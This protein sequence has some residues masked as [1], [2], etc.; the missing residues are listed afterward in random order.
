MH[1]VLLLSLCGVSVCGVDAAS[2]TSAL[3]TISV[4]SKRFLSPTATPAPTPEAI[5]YNS[6]GFNGTY[7]TLS[8][9]FSELMKNV[10]SDASPLS[11]SKVSGD[12]CGNVPRL[13]DGLDLWEWAEF[14]W[15]G[16]AIAFGN[17]RGTCC[18][19]EKGIAAD[20]PVAVASM[21]KMVTAYLI[22]RLIDQNLLTLETKVCEVLTWLCDENHDSLDWKVEVRHLLAQT[23]GMSKGAELTSCEGPSKCAVEA[24]FKS[25]K[26]NPGTMFKYGEGHFLVLGAI[27]VE[28]FKGLDKSEPSDYDRDYNAIFREII[29]NPLGM[30]HKSKFSFQNMIATLKLVGEVGKLAGLI[31]SGLDA[32]IKSLNQNAYL[33]PG[34]E[35]V[36]TLEDYSKFL[37]AVFKK[38]LVSETL[39]KKAEEPQTLSVDRKISESSV[40]YGFG[41]WVEFAED[42]ETREE[43][44]RSS[45]NGAFGSY[46][47][48]ER[49]DVPH[50]GLVMRYVL[51]PS[52]KLL[53]KKLLPEI[54]AAMKEKYASE[55][56]AYFGTE[57]SCPSH[58]CAWDAG[59]CQSCVWTDSA[60][61]VRYT[62]SS[63]FLCP[64]G[65]ANILDEPTCQEAAT[66]LSWSWKWQTGESDN[67]PRGCYATND[68][69]HV[70]LNTRASPLSAE[71]GSRAVCL[72]TWCWDTTDCPNGYFCSSNEC[73]V[74]FIR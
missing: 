68:P 70:F 69:V 43:P 28:K 18:T 5:I 39:V 63:G 71:D 3:P 32:L 49:S 42:D 37:H 1:L 53:Q 72:L 65:Y 34:G 62:A 41:Q 2:T 14:S 12:C 13:L 6:I 40:E 61:K 74:A 38:S 59:T 17:E 19:I 24:A 55:P 58:R 56:C 44:L 35:L 10:S 15:A 54:K 48:V 7:A 21:S 64:D 11:L 20:E 73:K 47:W 25:L 8:H 9:E 26:Q 45:S 31:W 60:C 46:P 22:L 33:G 36:I 4:N 67:R 52:M 27:A 50:W 29:A 23:S 57:V 30:S 66:A 51:P 16:A